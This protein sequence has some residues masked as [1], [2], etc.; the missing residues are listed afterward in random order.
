MDRPPLWRVKIW[1][2]RSA[3]RV[4]ACVKKIYYDADDPTS[5][6]VEIR[7][8]LGLGKKKVN[9]KS[10]PISPLIKTAVLPARQVRISGI[11]LYMDTLHFKLWGDVKW[12]NIIDILNIEGVDYF[13][14]SK[15]TIGVRYAPAH[16]DLVGI[17]AQC[18]AI[19]AKHFSLRT[20]QLNIVFYSDYT[21]R[22]EAPEMAKEIQ[23][24]AASTALPRS[25][26][27]NQVEARGNGPAYWLAN[28]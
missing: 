4:R 9:A 11:G 26:L 17:A 24:R 22:D 27:L 6:Y 15:G 2:E 14:V 1:T 25:V 3:M 19:I 5:R 8:R 7:R 12:R 23:T 28:H 18:V 21:C 13:Y 16:P 20:E 10:K